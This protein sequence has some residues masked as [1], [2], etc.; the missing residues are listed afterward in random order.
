MDTPAHWTTYG[1]AILIGPT[2]PL[3]ATISIYGVYRPAKITAGTDSNPFVTET[4]DLLRYGSMEKLILYNYEED[5]GRL[6]VIGTF[7]RRAKNG[8]TSE[9]AYRTGRAHRAKSRRAGA[10]RT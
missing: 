6:G 7:L 2:P 3:V 4:E 5:G 10:R 9:G 8:I 1:G